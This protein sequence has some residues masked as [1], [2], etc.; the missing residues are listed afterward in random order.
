VGVRLPAST[1]NGTTGENDRIGA[2]ENAVGSA[3]DDLLVGDDGPNELEGGRG[4]DVIWGRGGADRLE[5]GTGRDFLRGGAGSDTLTGGGFRDSLVCGSGD[6]LVHEPA[7]GE[8]LGPECESLEYPLGH[9][10]RDYLLVPVYP[11]LL[12]GGVR[13]RLVCP[14]VE[15]LDGH[16]VCDGGLTL[17]ETNGARRLL[18]SGRRID[19]DDSPR[20][21]VTLHLTAAGRHALVT[22]PHTIATVRIS[23]HH[24]PKRAWTIRFG[25]YSP[26]DRPMTSSMI[27]SVPAP[28]RFRRRSRHTRSTPYSCM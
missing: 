15:A 2:I 18:G 9:R 28:I 16:A 7:A 20:F 25:R 5:G 4:D 10:G 23:G 1:G 22:R 24:L 13:F 12:R 17:R 19:P 21:G 3:R 27:S 11:R 14:M 26:Y 8:V 6:D